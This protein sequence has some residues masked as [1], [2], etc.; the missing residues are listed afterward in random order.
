MSPIRIFIAAIFATSVAFGQ[1]VSTPDAQ[2]ILD[3]VKYLSAP[4]SAGRAPNTEG[5][6]RAATYISSQFKQADLLP[7]GDFGTYRN[8]FSITSAV[9]LVD[10][11]SVT[12]NTK[13]P[14]PGVPMEKIR[15]MKGQWKLG[16]DYQPFGFSDTGNVE[17]PI[18]F[19]GYG[20]S[21][22]DAK[23]DDYAGIDVK[24]AIVVVLD[25]SPEWA[26]DNP[27]I[28]PLAAMRTKATIARDKGAAAII[29]VNEK[30]DSADVLETIH[31]DRL[32]TNA[33]I[34]C[35]QVR[36]TPCAKLFPPEVKS[37]FVAEDEINKRKKPVSFLIPNSTMEISTHLQY[38]TGNTYNIV[39]AVEGSDD[40]LKGEY[41][42]VGAHYDHLGMGDYGSL[43]KGSAEIHYGADDNASG[44]AGLIELSQRIAKEPAKR[45]ILFIAFSGE[46][47]GLLGSK[48][49]V[50]TPTIPIENIK[51]MIN[52]DMIGRLKDHKLNVHGTGT[53][54]DWKSILDSATSGTEL[55]L[56]TNADGFGP[57]DHASFVP[58]KVP[59]L[60]FFTGLHSDYH[61]P[62]DTYEKL[63][64]DGEVTVLTAVERTIRQV[65]DRT[66]P[67]AFAEGAEKP[68]EMK[69]SGG[70]K[71]TL[72]IIP[73][74]SD[75]PQGLRIDGVR[76]N[77]PAEKAG[78]EGGD[79]ITQFGD[80][81]VK[82]IYDLTAALSTANPGD[83]VEIVILRNGEEKRLSA[84]LTGR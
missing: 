39:A 15:P 58:K 41:I 1:Q 52:M 24:G 64:Y 82:N 79:I 68:K 33:G 23:Y 27:H 16:G 47:R 59:A 21:A 71:V 30:G 57:S 35:L 31:L 36:R 4:E 34:I 6:E 62:S 38:V 37:L 17:G 19:V 55:V 26:K 48:H 74:Y 13:R 22:P 12:I 7:M 84:K 9:K 32:G 14:R 77:T 5:I 40:A 61:R 49:W 45:S 18:Y 65:A 81:R 8:A 73:D 28:R 29:I 11:N 43:H 42:V 63:N 66:S 76:E 78:L 75:D 60:H 69:T 44:T 80:T 20:I 53:S 67:I 3:H 51:A 2:R 83:V 50:A 70:F 10:P 56:A 46:E 54:V 72:G 25:G